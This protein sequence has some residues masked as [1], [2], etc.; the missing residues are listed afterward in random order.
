[1]G[2]CILELLKFVS[3]DDNLMLLAFL[4]C[5]PYMIYLSDLPVGYTSV[6]AF[7]SIVFLSVSLPFVLFF[8]FMQLTEPLE[9]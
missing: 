2:L 9:G 4:L 8:L 6:W 7:L 3:F 5:A 1:M